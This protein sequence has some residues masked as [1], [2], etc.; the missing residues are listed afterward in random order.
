MVDVPLSGK[1]SREDLWNM[2]NTKDIIPSFWILLKKRKHTVLLW[3]S[4]TCLAWT[5]M[6][7]TEEWATH[8]ESLTLWDE[9][10]RER[11]YLRWAMFSIQPTLRP[12]TP[13]GITSWRRMSGRCASKFVIYTPVKSKPCNHLTVSI[14]T[15]MG[16]FHWRSMWNMLWIFGTVSGKSMELLIWYKRPLNSSWYV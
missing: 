2:Q 16:S 13:M 12:S 14:K 6:Q 7:R 11:I 1:I 4:V 5:S 8:Y 15:K 9:S 10:W 3:P